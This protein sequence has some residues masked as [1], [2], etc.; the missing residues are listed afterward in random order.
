MLSCSPPRL[1]T[2]CRYALHSSCKNLTRFRIVLST[3]FLVVK[4]LL[5]YHAEITVCDISTQELEQ[6]K[7]IST[8]SHGSFVP[9]TPEI[10][11]KG[12][13][14]LRRRGIARGS[15]FAPSPTPRKQIERRENDVGPL[16]CSR[17]T[18]QH[19]CF[20]PHCSLLQELSLQNTAAP[21]VPA[22]ARWPHPSAC[23]R[24]A[25]MPAKTLWLK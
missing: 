20:L 4:T 17:K 24:L 19:P 25:G 22:A 5:R 12:P 7:H 15:H 18:Y 21:Q 6:P 16:L 8:T 11:S 9:R 10:A 2:S 14:G 13:N 23:D 3:F 1:S